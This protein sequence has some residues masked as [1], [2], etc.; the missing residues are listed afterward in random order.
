MAINKK[1]IKRE[2]EQIRCNNFYKMLAYIRIIKSHIYSK[3]YLYTKSNNV[4]VIL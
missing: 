3:V 2:I 4:V 1:L